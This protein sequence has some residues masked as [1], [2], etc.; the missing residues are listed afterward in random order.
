MKN[1][2][3]WMGML[4][5]IL[6]FGMMVVGCK[7]E[8]D[9]KE[10]VPYPYVITE[11][12]YLGRANLSTSYPW[13]TDTEIFAALQSVIENYDETD[14]STDDDTFEFDGVIYE[15]DLSS[16]AEITGGV[17]KVVFDNFWK[18]LKSYSAGLWSCWGY[19]YCSIPS[20]GAT[21]QA[22]VIFA[23]CDDIYASTQGS[24]Q[25]VAARAIIRKKI[26]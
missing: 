8:P 23:I 21:S 12:E 7:T 2:K 14:P 25:Y 18:E 19:V 11:L 5:M 1:G 15:M 17:P 6:V 3:T 20:K 4:V 24:I 10:K 22:Y 13:P 16:I 26:K 9:D